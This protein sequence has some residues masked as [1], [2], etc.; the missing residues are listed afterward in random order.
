MSAAI[1]G[2]A[3]RLREATDADFARIADI[4]AHHVRTGFGT[5]DEVPPSRED[6]VERFHAIAQ[7]G[8]PYLVMAEGEAVLAYAYAA[9]YRP[10]S[11]Y[12]FTVEDSIYVAPDSH[13]RGLGTNLLNRLAERC[14]AAG[15]RQ[16]VAV[17]GDSANL[18]SINLHA[19][20]GFRPI[21]VLNDVGYKG[22]R[23]LDAV[24]MQRTL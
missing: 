9:P 11:A 14:A 7:L 22:E 1:I 12:R 18:A 13:R 21:G 23:W 10:R 6:M 8:L 16:M 20:C 19:K 4:Y 17:I 24:I 5:F 2:A 3:L 15:M